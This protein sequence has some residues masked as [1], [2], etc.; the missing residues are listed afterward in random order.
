[1]SSTKFVVK[2][3]ENRKNYDKLFTKK[4]V[5]FRT[6]NSDYFKKIINFLSTIIDQVNFRFN[7]N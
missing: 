1:M 7:G 4:C 5:G 2:Y 3:S 6:N